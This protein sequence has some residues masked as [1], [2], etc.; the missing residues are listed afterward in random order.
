MGYH[1]LLVCLEGNCVVPLKV[2]PWWPTSQGFHAVAFL[3]APR[4]RV[5]PQYLYGYTWWY[6]VAT[7]Q[8]A[9]CGGTLKIEIWL[10]MSC[11]I[12]NMNQ[13]VYDARTDH[14]TQYVIV[15][16]TDTDICDEDPCGNGVCL[17]RPN[18]YSCICDDGWTGPSCEDRDQGKYCQIYTCWNKLYFK[19][20]YWTKLL[21]W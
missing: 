3:C 20:I 17:S 9:R 19:S 21:N 10:C 14:I 7:L 15:Y 12:I 6:Y 1:Q 4:Y 18:S 13:R 2:A 11:C 8:R 5:P 16:P